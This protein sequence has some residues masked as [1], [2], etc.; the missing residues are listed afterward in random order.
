[1][2]WKGM[3]IFLT[4][5]IVYISR[6]IYFTKMKEYLLK[7]MEERRIQQQKDKAY[8]RKQELESRKLRSNEIDLKDSQVATNVS[9]AKM[10]IKEKNHTIYKTIHID[11]VDVNN[12]NTTN[13][14]NKCYQNMIITM[15][16]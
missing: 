16:S 5:I 12:N 3:I 13:N 11:E 10:R 8:A 15:P 4:L 2:T 7:K 14:N 6:T 9:A 1:M